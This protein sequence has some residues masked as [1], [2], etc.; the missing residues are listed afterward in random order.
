MQSL[1]TKWAAENSRRLIQGWEPQAG[2]RKR[3]D[4]VL[5]TKTVSPRS[6]NCERKDRP[7]KAGNCSRNQLDRT[8]SSLKDNGSSDN[9]EIPRTLWNTTVHHRVQN[10]TLVLYMSRINPVHNLPSSIF[11]VHF[12]IIFSSKETSSKTFLS[13]AFDTK[14]LHSFLLSLKG[15]TCHACL[16]LLDVIT[17]ILFGVQWVSP[18]NQEASRYIF[19]CVLSLHFR[20]KYIFQCPILESHQLMF[21]S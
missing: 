11:K 20:P 21:L 12:N 16:I 9:Q 13:F 17:Q 7:P 2:T 1:N 3:Q 5:I 4:S 18:A 6:K 8:E 19:S 15:A 10:S 14:T